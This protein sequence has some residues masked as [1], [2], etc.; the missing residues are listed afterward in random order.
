[1]IIKSKFISIAIL[2]SVMLY[3]LRGYSQGKDKSLSSVFFNQTP[4]HIY[5]I[6]LSRP[7]DNAITASFLCSQDLRGYIIYGL[8]PNSLSKRSSEVYFKKDIPSEIELKNL[9]PGT[10]YYYRFIY[11]DNI[12]TAQNKSELSYFQTKRSTSEKFVFA[13]QADSHLDENTSTNAY[14]KTLHNISSD[15][16][17]FLIDLGDTWMTDKYSPNFT[18]AFK[19]YLAQRYYF[20]IVG[21]TTPVYF[22]LGNHDGEYERGGGRNTGVD[23]MLNWSTKIRKQYYF[24]PEP[25]GFYTGSVN[26]DQNYYAWEWGDALFIILDPFRYTRQNRDPWN[27]TLGKTQYDWLVSTLKSSSKKLK[28]VFIHNLVGGIDNKG[29]A[30]GGSEASIF[31]EWGGLNSDSTSGFSKHRPDWGLPIHDLLVKYNVC[32]VFHGHDHIFVKQ[33]RDSIIYQ[34]LPQPGAMRYGN[35]NS[36]TEYGYKSGI[37]LNAPGYLRITIVNSTAKIEYVQTSVDDKNLNKKVLYS[38]SINGIK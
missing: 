15:S 2:M 17:D 14:E 23:S 16:A 13:I 30:R 37:I 18:D 24:N 21:R 34:T 35:I 27:R 8:T 22:S 36:A 12:S 19:Q 32:A 31:Y 10:R 11:Y 38:Y 20:G 5:D 9:D 26:G 28:F 7:T 6:I 1:M 3:S 33:D 29:I 25:N 4:S